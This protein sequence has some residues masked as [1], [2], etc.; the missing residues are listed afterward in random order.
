[1]RR[2]IAA[3]AGAAAIALPAGCATGEPGLPPSVAPIEHGTQLHLPIAGYVPSAE[4]DEV[5]GRATL[6]LTEGCAR[7]FGV[8]YTVGSVEQPGILD[9]ADRRY[10]VIDVEEA[11]RS[12]YARAGKER[13]GAGPWRPSGREYEVVTGR[14]PTGGPATARAADGAPVPAGGCADEAWRRLGGGGEL[15]RLVDE[16]L[17][18]SWT[19]TRA[20]SRARAAE[21]A[22]TECMREAGHDFHHRW[23]AAESVGTSPP[24]EQRTMA[25]LDAT[26]AR[27]VNYVGIWHAVDSAYQERA[28]ARLGDRL[29]RASAER[30][31]LI[32][33]AAGIV[34]TG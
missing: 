14:T 20:D 4:E 34:G 33:R 2:L 26:C 1:M 6:V 7:R 15:T 28:I 10:G 5:I 16:V 11:A 9:G 3:V 30:R 24:A 12:G 23:D 29:P 17:R 21:T 22:W 32:A 19:Q 27:R 13:R 18:E 8:H 25:K 31:D